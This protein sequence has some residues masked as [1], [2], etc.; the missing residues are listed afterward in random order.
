VLREQVRGG[1]TLRGVWTTTAPGPVR[2]TLTLNRQP[3][4]G[5]LLVP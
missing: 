3:Y 4:G 1:E 5:D 2:F